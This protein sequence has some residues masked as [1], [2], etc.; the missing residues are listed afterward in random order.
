M[1]VVGAL[2]GLMVCLPLLVLVAL[3]VRFCL[4]RPV[5]YRQLRP[6]LGGRLFRL[7]KLRTMTD[8]RDPTGNL[9]CDSQRLTRLGALLRKTSLDELPELWNELRGEMSLVGPRPLLTEYLPYY[10][11]REAKRHT[12][13]PGIRC[14]CIPSSERI[15]LA[16]FA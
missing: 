8:A 6:G 15:H 7:Y 4:G 16:A 12:V 5:L 2:F 9:L 13:R 1:D 11:E 10:T 14:L 3:L